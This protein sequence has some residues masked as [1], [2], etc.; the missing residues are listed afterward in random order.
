VP[1]CFV[2]QNGP[3]IVCEVAPGWRRFLAAGRWVALVGGIVML[4]GAALSH[5]AASI[6]LL[7]I[8]GAWVVMAV[9][10]SWTSRRSAWRIVLAE[11]QLTFS[12]PS[13]DIRVPAGDLVEV[14]WGRWDF[15][16]V[17]GLYFRTRN[18]GTIRI[19]PQLRGLIALLVGLREVNTQIKLPE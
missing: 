17:A 13:L 14:R 3:V 19:A 10:G 6:A 8:G 18:A 7:V 9:A 16:H 2:S 4:I 1:G 11:G 12:G 15:Q 5:D